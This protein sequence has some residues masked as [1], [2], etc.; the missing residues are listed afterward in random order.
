M[1]VKILI[2]LAVV[3]AALAVVIAMRPDDFRVERS[4]TIAAP[5]SAIFPY[6]NS[7]R[8]TGE[9]A[10]WSKLDPNMK[11]TFTGPEEGV[12]STVSWDGN[13]EVGAGT[14]TITESRPDELVRVKLDFL[15]PFKSTST[16]DFTLKPEGAGTTVTWAMYGK[17]NF[18]SKAMGL[19]MDCEKMCGDMFTKGL[20][21]LK[22][23]VE[24]TPQS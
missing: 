1:F 5:P 23:L 17:A 14:S 20:T 16:A 18:I 15:R 12:G 6:L 10:P 13:N 22:T 11:Q 24:T 7:Q 9:W 4:M 19:F 8:K 3:L 2:G 21:D